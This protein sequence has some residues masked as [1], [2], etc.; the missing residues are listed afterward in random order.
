MR[1]A[2]ICLIHPEAFLMDV[3]IAMTYWD[4]FIYVMIIVLT[5]FIVRAFAKSK[6]DWEEEDTMGSI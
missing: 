1:L 3:L 5:V 2:A 6:W 4:V